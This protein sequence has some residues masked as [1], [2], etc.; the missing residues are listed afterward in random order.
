[1]A[2]YNLLFPRTCLGCGEP[3][4]TNVPFCSECITLFSDI[5]VESCP[6]CGL[7]PRECTCKGDEKFLFFYYSALSKNVLFNFKHFGNHCAYDF[8]AAMIYNKL[9][10]EKN[11]DCIVYPPR[12]D[13]NVFK[14]GFDQMEETAKS[15]SKLFGIPCV[16]ALERVRKS[17]EQKLLSADQRKTNVHGLFAADKDALQGMKRVLLIDDV[18]TTGSTFRSCRN[19]LRSA[20]VREIVSFAICK[21]PKIHKEQ[22]VK[23]VNGKSGKFVMTKNAR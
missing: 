9:R 19:A 16:R 23:K 5:L 6:I 8:F 10:Y 1:M 14:Y 15:L 20:G 22:A 17:K 4:L 7:S 11:F 12:S 18:R 13:K 21:T 2:L 3:V